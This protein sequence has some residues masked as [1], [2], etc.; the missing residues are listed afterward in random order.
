MAGILND[1]GDGFCINRGDYELIRRSGGGGGLLFGNRGDD[2]EMK[3]ERS[4]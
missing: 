2:K 1:G 4:D 3:T